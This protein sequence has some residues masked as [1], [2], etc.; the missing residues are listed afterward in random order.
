MACE[1]GLRE[2]ERGRERSLSFLKALALLRSRQGT[3]TGMKLG[4]DKCSMHTGLY[5][6]YQGNRTRMFIAYGTAD[7]VTPIAL[8]KQ[9][10]DQWS[11]VHGVTWTKNETNVPAR[12]WT[13][14]IYGDGA[15]LVGYSVQGGGHIP[16]FQADETL[17][18]FGLLLLLA[19]SPHCSAV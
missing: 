2:R 11:N 3:K 12:T 18:F 14:I 6:G 15:K 10:L 7:T 19:M 1:L 8:L 4:F 16:P 9:Q 17:K 13:K 5:P